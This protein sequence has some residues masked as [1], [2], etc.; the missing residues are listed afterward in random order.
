[1]FGFFSRIRERARAAVLLG[2]ADAADDILGPD[3]SPADLERVRAL[4]AAPERV[5]ALPAEGGEA[6]DTPATKRRK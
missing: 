2:V 1:M 5:A 3:A 6:D 4:L